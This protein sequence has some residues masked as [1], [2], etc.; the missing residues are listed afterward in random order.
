MKNYK[1]YIAIMFLILVVGGFLLLFYYN[2][3]DKPDEIII[4][5]NKNN[6]SEVE[7]DTSKEEIEEKEEVYYYVDIKGAIN[8]PNVYKVL[9]DSRIIDVINM[10]GGLR[11]DA[12]TSI[13][14]LSKKVTDEMF[15][16]IYT[17]DELQKYKEQTISTEEIKKKIE[18]E[19]VVVD[20]NNDAEVISEEKKEND[21][22][23][24]NINTASKEELL[25]ISGIGESK[26][27][28]IIK[29]RE[30]NGNFKAIDDIKNVSGIGD[31]LFEKIKEFITV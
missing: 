8:N 21:N 23:F 27:E 6:K 10:A 3:N 24:V 4:N 19:I 30:E 18:E 5:G 15:I 26:A 29:Y 2:Y 7:K 11:E 28:S 1:L 9:K 14:N 25:T 13:I 17:K 16:V 31:S 20:R 12:D 22:K